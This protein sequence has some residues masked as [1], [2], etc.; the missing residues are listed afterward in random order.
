MR[1]PPLVG[2][3]CTLGAVVAIAALSIVTADT[4]KQAFTKHQKAFYADA[5]TINFV[6]PGL[7]LKVTSANVA[8]DGTITAHIRITDPKTLPLD[9][10]GITT[11][12]AV[13]ISCVA[14]YIPKGQTQYVAYTTRPQTSPITGVTATQAATD[15]GG[16]FT[17]TADGEYDYTF[18]TKAPAGFDATATHSIGCQAS[19]NLSEFDLPTNYATDVY[20]FVPNGAPVTVTRDV[21]RDPSCN[22]CHDEVAFHGGSRRGIAYCVM[23][24]TP[25]TTDPDTGNTVDMPVMIHRI[26]A[27]SSLPSVQA[28]G[29]YQI[30]GHNQSVADYSSVAFPAD[31]RRCEVCHEQ[32]TQAAQATAYLKPSMA[33]CGAC[34]DNVNFATGE[35]HV[36]LPQISNSQCA[37]CHIAQG[38]LEFDASIKGAHV[39]PEH[40][41]S[42]GGVVVEIVKVENGT[43]GKK[44]TVTFTLKDS[45]GNP[46]PLDSMKASPNRVALVM[47][48][49]TTDYGYTNFGSDV[50]TGGYVSENPVPS[51]SCDSNGICTYTF[52]HAIPEDAKGT[53]AIGI[54]ARRGATLL[55]GTQKEINTEYGAINK[56]AYFSVDGSPVVPR[57]QVVDI[58]KCNGCHEFLSLHGENRNQ[59]EQCVLCHNA[60]ETDKAR[61]P[62]AQDPNDKAQPAQAVNFAYMIHRIHTGEK[63]QEQGAG[64]TVV[65][66]GGS[67]N[68][69][70]EVRYPAF[71]PSG[72]PGDTRN[73]GMCHVNGSEQNL[74]TGKNAM[75]HPQGPWSPMGAVAAAC[76][77]CHANM[78]AASHALANTTT[79]GESCAT[80]H[81]ADAE[82]NVTRAHAR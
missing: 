77:G 29:K 53:F 8:S 16:K 41:N 15:S 70:S 76:T 59:I 72:S 5:N 2:R 48:G 27:G 1:I 12:G 13:S 47:A 61:R 11:P 26:H 38:E 52:T 22:R 18:K 40:S 36:N 9:R 4:S 10:D 44:P 79:L 14:A 75:T 78:P 50:T 49:P 43:A 34:H 31:V 73:C 7:V 42:V 51:A 64:Y 57:R 37:N 3:V 25:Q 82:F 80:C 21:I 63:L 67:H 32:N 74:P 6:R 28:G 45:A 69:F 55:A 39:I 20:T 62:S 46:I 81:D 17:K 65:G 58:Q 68:D 54:E 23:C 19:R 30:I 66:F 56:V 35:N 60:S 24:H 33:A 71:S